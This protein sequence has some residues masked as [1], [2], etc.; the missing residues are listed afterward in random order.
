MNVK[1][2]VC[3]PTYNGSS[4]LAETLESILVQTFRDIEI[5]VIDD[6]SKDNSLE[7]AHKFAA[8]DERIRVVQ[9]QINLGLVGNWNRCVELAR[10]EWIKFVFQDDLIEPTCLEKMLAVARPE[11]GIVA[12]RREFVFDG[13]SEKKRKGFLVYVGMYDIEKLLPGKT[14]ITADEFSLVVSDT[15]NHNFVGE[16]T[17]MLLHRNLFYR[18]G[19]FNSHL[20]QVCDMEYWAR[21]GVNRGITYIPETLAW[22]RVHGNS[23]SESNGAKRRNQVLMLDEML[24]LHD[25]A[26]NPVYEPLRAVAARREPP[27]D[28]CELLAV[29]V[30]DT[31][32]LARKLAGDVSQSDSNLNLDFDRLKK[33]YPMLGKIRKMPFSR[34]L[35]DLKW[36]IRSVLNKN[37]G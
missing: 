27:V 9:N 17:S 33:Y 22:F 32:R 14:Q 23:M 1:V 18:F 4:Y 19:V 24:M 10:G 35:A 29:K 11:I 25:Y 5:L 2:S 12:C 13:I 21:V 34:R 20:I 16:P 15:I 6:Q 31:K 36:T 7:I 3:I 28:F 26:F 37:K 8:Q 30:R